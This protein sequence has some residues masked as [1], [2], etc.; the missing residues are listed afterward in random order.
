MEDHRDVA[1]KYAQ[2]TRIVT[3]ITS[4]G[5]YFE[6]EGDRF[7]FTSKPGVIYY[8]PAD[9]PIPSDDLVQEVEDLAAQGKTDEI[10]TLLLAERILKAI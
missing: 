8:I 1:A 5:D 7:G 6:N 10:V 2:N 3:S 9:A 4:L